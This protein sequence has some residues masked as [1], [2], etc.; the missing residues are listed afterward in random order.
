MTASDEGDMKTGNSTPQ[1]GLFTSIAVRAWG[2]HAQILGKCAF[3]AMAF[4]KLYIATTMDN[5]VALK[6][7]IN[8][9][10][11]PMIFP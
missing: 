6:Q 2:G 8:F 5:G 4:S 7:G 3:S 11:V 1:P 10:H 9:L